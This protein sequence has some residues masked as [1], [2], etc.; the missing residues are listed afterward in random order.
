[1]TMT[2]FE[3]MY[4]RLD[5]VRMSEAD[6][7]LA[8]AHLEQAE[9]LAEILHKGVSALARLIRAR[10]APAPRSRDLGVRASS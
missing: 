2:E 7:H 8:R 9:A 1:M 10:S 6:R 4:A 5:R 3:A